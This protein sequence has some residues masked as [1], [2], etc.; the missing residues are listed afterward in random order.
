[1][2]TAVLAA[3]AELARSVPPAE[4]PAV[5]GAAQETPVLTASITQAA[6]ITR[7][8]AIPPATVTVA[9]GDTLSGIADAHG[10]DWLALYHQNATVV[11]PDPGLIYPG[12]VLTLPQPGQVPAPAQVPTGPQPDAT[13]QPAAPPG[14]A[15]SGASPVTP[16]S[17]YEAC[18]IARESG[19]NPQAMNASQHWGLY[20]FAAGT[21]AAAGGNPADFGHAGPAEQQQVFGRAYALWGT[22]PWSP[23]DGCPS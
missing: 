15:T 9:S 12:Q 6:S 17:A 2:L 10:V 3:T 20:Q 8:E 5:M 7:A 13:V 21:W 1:M 4:L 11:G 23:S 16:H 19:G 22:Q 18:V 14:A